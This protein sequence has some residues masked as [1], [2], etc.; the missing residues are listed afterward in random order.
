MKRSKRYIYILLF[1]IIFAT[2]LQELP[3][4]RKLAHKCPILIKLKTQL[5]LQKGSAQQI[6]LKMYYWP[7]TSNQKKNLNYA[8]GYRFFL[9]LANNL[10]QGSLLEVVGS[11]NPESAKSFFQQKSLDVQSVQLLTF[12][13]VSV[14]FWWLSWRRLASRL[15]SYLLESI[16][17]FMSQANLA[18]VTGMVFGGGEQLNESLRLAFEVTG[19]THVVS[20]SGYNLS[21]IAG[22]V[23]GVLNRFLGRRASGLVAIFFIW[24][25]SLMADLTPPIVRAALM[26]TLNLLARRVF[27][28][29][30]HLQFSLCLSA[31]LILLFQPYLIRSLSFWLSMLATSGIILVLPRL[32]SVP[33]TFFRRF[34]YSVSPVEPDLKDQSFRNHQGGQPGTAF[35]R[36]YSGIL[37]ELKESF[38]VTLAAQILTV[39]LTALVFGQVSWLSLVANPLLLWLTPPI[40]LWGLGLMIV[41]SLIRLISRIIPVR[42]AQSTILSLI[43]H[44][45]SWPS[46]LFLS[47]VKWFGR[48]QWGLIKFR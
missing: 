1:I 29:Q 40:T 11:P 28:R 42:F 34:T 36:F 25:Y 6:T 15:R 5:L 2:I 19:L 37:A 21:V 12:K 31:G 48:W 7:L 20:A 16:A 10:K 30:Y 9:P 47:G 14:G 8:Q 23:L 13:P 46:Q 24:T 38:L 4:T 18:L 33:G 44:L 43:G 3:L 17:V 32:N 35:K 26:L 41:A 39:P 22:L 27:L 45:I